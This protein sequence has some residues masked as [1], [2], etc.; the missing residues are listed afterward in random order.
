MNGS[1]RNLRPTQT[2]TEQILLLLLVFLLRL[3]CLEY[4]RAY[5]DHDAERRAPGAIRRGR[6]AGDGLQRKRYLDAPFAGEFRGCDHRGD[7]DEFGASG[8]VSDGSDSR[9]N[10]EHA[11]AGHC[12]EVIHSTR[13][14]QSF[15]NS[16]R[17]GRPVV[18]LYR[19]GPG[20]RGGGNALPGA[21]E[22]GAR[23]WNRRR[24]CSWPRCA[25]FQRVGGSRPGRV[26]CAF[27]R[28][29]GR[30]VLH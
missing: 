18:L 24:R 5:R 20:G 12:A 16:Q 10:Y 6:G 11:R 28:P 14:A 17:E 22:S 23:R 2:A 29:R 3:S 27:W 8:R 9:S 7:G 21:R 30:M 19:R 1:C 26:R 25:A 13:A 15:G 4:S